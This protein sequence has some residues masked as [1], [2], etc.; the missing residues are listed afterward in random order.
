MIMKYYHLQKY[1]KLWNKLYNFST[2]LQKH[3]PFAHTIYVAFLYRSGEKKF[4]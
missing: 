3:I 2:D 1:S 4:A